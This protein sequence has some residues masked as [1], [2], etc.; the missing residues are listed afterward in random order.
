KELLIDFQEVVDE[1][2]SEN[3]AKVVWETLTQYGL[4]EWIIAFV[5]DN[6]TNNDTMVVAIEQCCCE[7][8]VYFSAKE[9]RMCC[10][11]HTIHLAAIKVQ[12]ISI[13]H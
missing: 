13:P 1:H 10:M 11:P 4:I 12:T 8:G 9:V 7:V 5:M 2:S 3:M 6:A